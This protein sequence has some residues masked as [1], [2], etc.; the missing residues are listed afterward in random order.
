MC[1]IFFQCIRGKSLAV[2]SHGTIIIAAVKK[3]VRQ[4]AE[5][6][7]PFHYDDIHENYL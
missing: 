6:A 4:T 1:H 5:L 7:L 2:N 3:L